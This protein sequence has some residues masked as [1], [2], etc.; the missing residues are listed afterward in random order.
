MIF[1]LLLTLLLRPLSLQVLGSLLASN[2]IY[3]LE[4]KE[5]NGTTPINRAH[6]I[7]NNL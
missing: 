5:Q 3:L 4:Q 6:Q 2:Y 7:I 1:C